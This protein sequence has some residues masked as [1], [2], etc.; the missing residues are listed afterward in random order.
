M[1]EEEFNDCKIVR[2]QF[3][4]MCSKYKDHSMMKSSSQNK[5]IFLVFDSNRLEN[6]LPSGVKY[7]DTYKLLENISLDSSNP[8]TP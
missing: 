2:E 1:S 4:N 6:T 3:Q 7:N 8:V 5:V